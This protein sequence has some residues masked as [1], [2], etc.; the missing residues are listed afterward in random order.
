[1][2]PLVSLF[3]LMVPGLILAGPTGTKCPPAQGRSETCVC[4]PTG[5]GVIDMTPLSN[6][7]G[8]ARYSQNQY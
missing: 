3:L 2:V 1:M 6:V 5:G 4:Q 7:D 8:T